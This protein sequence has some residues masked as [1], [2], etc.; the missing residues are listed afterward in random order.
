MIKKLYAALFA[1]VALSGCATNYTYDGQKYTSKEA[2]FT[3]VD[4]HGAV[5]LSTITPL[6][7]PLSEKQL[8]FAIPSVAAWSDQGVNNFIKTQGKEPTEPQK[9]VARNLISANFKN[10][11]IFHDGVLKKNI[12][13]SVKFVEMAT[14]T[15][16]FAPSPDTDTLFWV[17]PAANSSQ[18]FYASHKYGKQIFAYD[19]SKT[20]AEGKL[21]AFVE[22]VQAQAI[23]E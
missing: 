5:V 8:I 6:P 18:W 20:T 23:R 12:Y 19:R 14:T 22:A 16:D 4:N 1:V 10:I 11:K 9:E 17:A 13:R 21:Q 3:A 2:L 15:G 7:T